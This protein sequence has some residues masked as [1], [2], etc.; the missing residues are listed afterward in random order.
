MDLL[1]YLVLPPTANALLILAGL[2]LIWFRWK[3]M[4]SSFVLAGS[5]TL[6]LL[7]LPVVSHGLTQPLERYP[8][9]KLEDLDQQQAII[10]LGGGRAY[11]GKE[12]GWQ[13]APS[14]AN[15]S[16]LNYG[17]WLH[18]KTGL[19]LLLTGGSKHGETLS[20][21]QL[22]QQTLQ[23]SFGIQARW[24]EE[25]SRTTQENAYYTAALLQQENLNQVILVSHAWH[26]A[27]AVPTF[28][29]QGLQVL[30]APLQFSTP[31]PEGLIGWMPS[32][33]HL[34]K[35]TLAIHEYLGRVAYQLR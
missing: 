10:I 6:I 30:P 16:R 19:P 13:N 28:E 17:A 31:P 20:E 9:L 3:K 33:Y 35:S 5:L 22:M 32:A 23:E 7:S 12:F 11:S 21:A 4:G 18:R 15:L 27:R 14:E 8:A 29:N 26:L 25:Q 34:R 2:G 1:K 24:L